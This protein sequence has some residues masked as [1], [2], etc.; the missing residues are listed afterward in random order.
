MGYASRCGVEVDALFHAMSLP[1]DDEKVPLLALLG[2]RTCGTSLRRMKPLRVTKK[3][4]KRLAYGL[5]AW[6]LLSLFVATFQPDFWPVAAI[7]GLAAGLWMGRYAEA[8][9]AENGTGIV[10]GE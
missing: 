8:T 4:A 5:M 9:A 6:F 1:P 3:N 7:S 2:R 10:R